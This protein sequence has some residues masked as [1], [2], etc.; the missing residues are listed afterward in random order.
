MPKGVEVQVLSVAPLFGIVVMT[1]NKTFSGVLAYLVGIFISTLISV[2]VKKTMVDYK[3]PSW[4]VVFIREVIVCALLL[5]FMIKQK[6]NFFQKYA[7]KMNLARNVLYFMSTIMFYYVMTKLPV[8]D[9]ISIEFLVPILAGIFS[10]IFLKEKASKA[11]WLSLFICIGGA[12]VVKRP[13]LSNQ[14]EFIAYIMLLAVVVMRALIIMMNGKLA[15]EFNTSTIL[16]YANI[17]LL[18]FSCL[19][20]PT[21]IKPHPVAILILVCCGVLYTIEYWFIFSAH[22]WCTVLTLQPCEFS[23]IIYSMVLSSLILSEATTMNQIYGSI[24][25]SIGFCVMIFGKKGIAVKKSKINGLEK[26]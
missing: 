21:F 19:F 1:I 2:F 14:P 26:Q 23:K 3:L 16:F 15:Y 12:M 13:S 8:N 5:P 7:L 20:A 25:I 18:L 22:K 4:E 6:F 24:I 17:L 11:V 10:S 9:C